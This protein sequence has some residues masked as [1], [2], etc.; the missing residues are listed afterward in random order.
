MSNLSSEIINVLVVE[1]SLMAAMG[2]RAVLE[3]YHCHVDI[4]NTGEEAVEKASQ[5]DYDI[6]LM[7]L[8]LPKMQGDEAAIIIKENAGDSQVKILALSAHDDLEER[9]RAKDSGID[10]F[11]S[12]PLTGQKCELILSTFAGDKFHPENGEDD[13]YI[14]TPRR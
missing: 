13:S 2:A 7:D 11:L 9:Y 12:K 5:Q 6:I 4:A 3:K 1:D 14:A 8:G 10:R